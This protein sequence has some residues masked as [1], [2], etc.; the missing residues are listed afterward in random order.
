MIS[1]K[2]LKNWHLINQNERVLSLGLL[3]ALYDLAWHGANI[4]PSAGLGD[5][6]EYMQCS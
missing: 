6:F 5:S 3:E 4:C 1:E 2:W